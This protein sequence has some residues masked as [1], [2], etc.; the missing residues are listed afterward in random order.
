MARLN[1]MERISPGRN[2]QLIPYSLFAR[3]RALDTVDTTNPR[4]RTDSEIRAGLDTKM[5]VSDALTFDFALNPDFSQVESNEPQV[6]INERFEVFFPEKRPF[7]LENSD[8]FKTPVNLFFSR[9]IAD[10]QFGARMTGKVGRWALGLLGMD[11]RGPGNNRLPSDPLSGHRAGAG[12]LSVHREFGDQNLMGVLVTSRDFAS[13]SNRVFSFDTRLKL[14]PNW[15]FT[16]QMIKSYTR[17]LDGT[18]HSGPAFSTG[19]VYS[20]R[21]LT[22]SGSYE[23]RSPNFDGNQL[24]FIPRVDTRQMTHYLNYLW[25]PEGRHVLSLG[26]TVSTLIN[27]NHQGQ[28]QDWSVDGGFGISF[29]NATQV[30]VS[31]SEAFE[32]FNNLGFRKQSTAFSFSTEPLRWFGI[33]ATYGWGANINFSPAAGLSPFL[34]N[35]TTGTFELTLRPTPQLRLDH[36][37]IYSRLGTRSENPSGV[38]ASTSIFNNHIVRWKANYQFTRALSLRAIVDYNAVLANPSLI[39]QQRT[40]NLTGDILLVYLLN[41]GTALYIGYTDRRENLALDPALPP[42]MQLQRIVRPTTSTGRQ[43]FVKLSYLFRF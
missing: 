15:V 26:P 7:F 38:P 9:R 13:S 22:Y 17:N 12:V 30:N 31:Q 10:P 41:P 16:G 19:M 43:F 36:T 21:H 11:D 37:Y 34:A 23:D 2:L 32:L 6:T 24:G 35:S 29:A 28:V 1:G 4:F 33:S 25:R 8:F 39:A 5:I 20:A 18:R 27:W 42:S 3:A 14:S 40:K